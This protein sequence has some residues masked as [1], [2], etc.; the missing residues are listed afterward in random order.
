MRSA[1]NSHFISQGMFALIEYRKLVF[2]ALTIYVHFYIIFRLRVSF[3]ALFFMGATIMLI[4]KL[5]VH[6]HKGR[7]LFSY[8]L[9]NHL[10]ANG[11]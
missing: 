6:H 4:I 1:I 8:L 10:V 3:E 7:S 11:Y 9:I 2:T 5:M